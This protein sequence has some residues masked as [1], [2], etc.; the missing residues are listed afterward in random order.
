MLFLTPAVRNE[1]LLPR[2]V[3]PPLAIRLVRKWSPRNWNF[4]GNFMLGEGK[5]W[6]LVPARGGTCLLERG[7]LLF[8]QLVRLPCEQVDWSRDAEGSGTRRP[9]L[10]Q[11]CLAMHTFTL[12]L[13]LRSRPRRWTS[14]MDHCTS[15][16]IFPVRQHWINLPSLLFMT[17]HL[18][19]WSVENGS[20]V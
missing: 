7:F 4:E 20:Q 17:I 13:N 6:S 19:N 5:G 12:Y 2:L 10:V 3:P 15:P 18:L 11:D 9:H 16:F 1:D 14:G 8:W